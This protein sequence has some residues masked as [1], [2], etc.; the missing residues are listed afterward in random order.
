MLP[1]SCVSGCLLFS[2]VNMMNTADDTKNCCVTLLC[3]GAE[4]MESSKCHLG[5]IIVRDLSTKV[6]R[7]LPTHVM[8]IQSTID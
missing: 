4:D 5:A 7:L 2:L 8:L 3:I 6:S 1:P